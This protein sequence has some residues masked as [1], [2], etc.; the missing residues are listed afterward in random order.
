M[1]DKK[2][3]GLFLTQVSSNSRQESEVKIR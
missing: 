1:V 2:D 3:L